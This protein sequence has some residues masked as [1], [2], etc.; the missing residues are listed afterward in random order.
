MGQGARIG[1]LV[2]FS[3]QEELDGDAVAVETAALHVFVAL[4]PAVDHGLGCADSVP[5]AEEAEVLGFDFVLASW[6]E[7]LEFRCSRRC[8]PSWTY[9]VRR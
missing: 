4:E 2:G 3:L 9:T 5:V 8:A 7:T 1:L 6:P